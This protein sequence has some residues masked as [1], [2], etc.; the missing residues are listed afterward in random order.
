[1]RAK[2]FLVSARGILLGGAPVCLKFVVGLAL[3]YVWDWDLAQQLPTRC[4]SRAL[5]GRYCSTIAVGC[6]RETSPQTW[7]FAGEFGGTVA[8]DSEG[9]VTISTD[10]REA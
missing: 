2:R 6:F 3:L 5:L 8:L 10:S 9:A 4:N 1:M 7:T